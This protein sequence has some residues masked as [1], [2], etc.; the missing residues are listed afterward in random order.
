M[1]L[2]NIN[3]TEVFDFSNAAELR[4]WLNR[5]EETDLA[6]VYFIGGEAD[7]LQFVWE[8][9]RLSDGSDVHNIRIRIR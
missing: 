9:E 8:T 6:A 4:D 7:S 3:Y 2:R 1:P 5:F